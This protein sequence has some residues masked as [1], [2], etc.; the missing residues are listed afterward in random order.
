MSRHQ[1]TFEEEGHVYRLGKHVLPSVTTVLKATGAYDYPEEIPR[2][3]L[4]A[5]GIR[6]D[7]VHAA[8]H[9]YHQTGTWSP[10]P[11]IEGYLDAYRW[12]ES[13]TGFVCHASEQRLFCPKLY[14]AGTI[15][16]AGSIYEDDSILDLKSTVDLNIEATRIQ[17]AAYHW[18]WTVN[19]EDPPIDP[20]N[21]FGLHLKPNGR[22]RLEQFDGTYSED[23]ASFFNRY[24]TYCE[25]EGFDWTIL[26]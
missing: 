22:Y 1:L 9:H 11:E 20:D 19:D 14:F 3:R 26:S 18:L 17:T 21:R 6:G 2:H 12:F 5:A 8:V 24:R 15:D 25:R 23:L 10:D 13:D 4:E 16:E 7:R